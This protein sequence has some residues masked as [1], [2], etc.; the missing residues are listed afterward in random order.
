MWLPA[1]CHASPVSALA[2]NVTRGQLQSEQFLWD[3]SEIAEHDPA[4]A[5]ALES[6]PSADEIAMSIINRFGSALAGGR[7]RIGMEE[8]GHMSQDLRAVLQLEVEEE[9]FDQFFNARTGYR[10]QFKQDC[11]RGLAY[12][13]RIVGGMRQKLSALSPRVLARRLSAD[14]ED[15]GAIGVSREQLWVSLDPSLSKVWF[16]SV[17]V[18]GTGTVEQLHPGLTG[19]R[20]QLDA[21]KTWAAIAPSRWL[22]LKGAFVGSSGPY[23]PKLPEVRAK[24]LHE[25]GAA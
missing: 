15:R 1:G 19:P 16:C 12:N 22:D 4:R 13:E 9:F 6:A 20:L 23:Q 2:L 18:T 7:V 25:S 3:F 10:A 17:L 8:A 5:A 24:G 14:F 21:G 11:Q